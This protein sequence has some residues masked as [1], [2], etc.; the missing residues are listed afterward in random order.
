M[1]RPT[2]RRAL[3][4]FVAGSEV[5]R[6]GSS[7]TGR[8]GKIKAARC[9]RSAGERWSR[10]GHGVAQPRRALAKAHTLRYRATLCGGLQVFDLTRYLTPCGD[11]R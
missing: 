8:E 5:A 6:A 2:I 4:S 11:G 10:T 1:S 7:P 9:G 3:A